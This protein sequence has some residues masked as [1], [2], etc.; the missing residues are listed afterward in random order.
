D[1]SECWW[2]AAYG[3]TSSSAAQRTHRPRE[4]TVR[5]VLAIGAHPDD[6]EL[7]CGASLLAHSAAGDRVTMLVLTGGENGPGTGNRHAEQRAAATTLGAS[8]RW[9]GLVDCTLTP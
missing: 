8:L 5:N 4:A 6:I 1:S 7:G 2:S 3:G 9:G